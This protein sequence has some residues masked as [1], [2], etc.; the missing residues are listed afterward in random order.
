MRYSV[1]MEASTNRKWIAYTDHDGP[2][3]TGNP[4]N[5]RLVANEAPRRMFLYSVVRRFLPV[6]AG[7]CML[8]ALVGS[9]ANIIGV[10]PV[11]ILVMAAFFCGVML[12][13]LSLD[14]I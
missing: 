11:T 4:I 12:F 3:W 7:L 1:C 14:D 6:L 13:S 2:V 9:F 8:V 5:I 10:V